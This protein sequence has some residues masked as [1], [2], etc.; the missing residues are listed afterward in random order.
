VSDAEELREH[1]RLE[2]T[3]P[4]GGIRTGRIRGSPELLSKPMVLF[5]TRTPDQF[6]HFGAKLIGQLPDVQ[7]LIAMN[8]HELSDFKLQTKRIPA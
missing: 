6:P 3:E 2:S 7:I 4:F 1:P 8:S 5:K